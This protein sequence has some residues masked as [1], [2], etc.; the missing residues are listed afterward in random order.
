MLTI[1]YDDL[2]GALAL[3]MLVLICLLVASRLSCRRLSVV[4]WLFRDYFVVV[5]QSFRDCLLTA[6]LQVNA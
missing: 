5:L 3:S 6:S 1:R 2:T 4:L